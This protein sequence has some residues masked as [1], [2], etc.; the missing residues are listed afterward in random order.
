MIQSQYRSYCENKRFKKAVK[1]VGDVHGLVH[2]IGHGNAGGNY[3]IVDCNNTTVNLMNFHHRNSL[4][5][6]SLTQP[7]N[8]LK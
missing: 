5:S 2:G 7:S 1:D 4:T 6:N 8:G 3:S